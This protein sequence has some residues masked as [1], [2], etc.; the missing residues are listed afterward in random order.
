[1][2]AKNIN[3]YLKDNGIKQTWLA[4]QVDLPISTFHGIITG[5][6]AMKADLFIKICNVLNVPPERFSEGE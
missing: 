3:E 1:M 4:E 2:L 6:V 5:K